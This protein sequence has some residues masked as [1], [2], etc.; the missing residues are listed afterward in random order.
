ML[1]KPAIEDGVKLFLFNQEIYE[2]KKKPREAGK[3]DLTNWF[4]MMWKLIFVY[5]YFQFKLLVLIDLAVETI[6]LTLS[7]KDAFCC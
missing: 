6:N 2:N 4:R 1:G 7:L 3:S 5:I